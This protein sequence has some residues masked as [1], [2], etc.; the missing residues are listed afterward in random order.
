MSNQLSNNEF[1]HIATLGK[2]VGLKGFMKL[3]VVSDFPELFD[4]GRSFMLSNNQ[5]IT[6]EAIDKN[7]VKIQGVNS[8]Q[9]TKRFINKKLF[10]SYQQTRENC[11]LQENQ[12]F[13]FDI[14]GSRILENNQQLGIVAT[15]E[16]IAEIDYLLIQTDANLIAQKLP[17]S[18]LIPYQDKYILHVD[19]INKTIL[20]SGGLDILAAS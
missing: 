11:L 7:L 2:S 6:I 14:I 10:M 20:V 17:K 18:F 9:E 19:T 5:N 12:Y 8:L 3:H 4:A 1:L 16:R 15:I 13:Y